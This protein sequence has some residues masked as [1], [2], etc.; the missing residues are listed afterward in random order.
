MESVAGA[1]T[2]V[3]DGARLETAW[4]GP[5]SRASPTLVLLHEGLGCIAL[6]RKFPQKLATATGCG[7]FVYS[8]RGYGGSDPCDL[9][10]P[11]D[12]MT[13]EA[14]D[15]LPRVLDAAGIETAILVGHSDGA[16]IAAIYAGSAQDRRVRGIVLMAP[17]FFA[18]PQGFEAIAATTKLYDDGGLREKLGR[19]H[20]H[21]DVAF[22][23][24]S[25]TWLRPEFRDWNVEDVIAFIRVPILAIQG[26]ADAYGTW[27]QI[28]VLETQVYCPLDVARLACGHAPFLERPDEVLALIVDFVA[29]LTRIEAA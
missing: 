3:V 12:Y 24:W 25:G 26:D 2:I 11:C 22:R 15:V 4:H 28:T 20:T 5:G 17:H 8:R 9:P 13:R 19:Y 18:E 14:L 16:T 23:G 27:A 7:V 6:W 1:A 29:R 10:R 21:V